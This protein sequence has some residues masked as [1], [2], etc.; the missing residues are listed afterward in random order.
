MADMVEM[1]QDLL[2]KEQVAF[3]FCKLTRKVT[4]MG[5][6]GDI[7]EGLGLPEDQVGV[8]RD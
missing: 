5:L 4:V 2:R 3:R 7:L 1:Q 6:S 8:E